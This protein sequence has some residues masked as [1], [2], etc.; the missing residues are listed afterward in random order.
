MGLMMTCCCVLNAAVMPLQP[1]LF[2]EQLPPDLPPELQNVDWNQFI[3]VLST[4][5]VILYLVVL[6]IPS[7][8]LMILGFGVRKGARG[9]MTAAKVLIWLF[10]ALGGLGLV[11]SLINLAVTSQIITLVLPALVFGGWLWLSLTAIAKLK[12]ASQSSPDMKRADPW[13]A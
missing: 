13:G 5:L 2:M 10:A 3:V 8:V 9:Q 12:I 4:V 6:L 11:L 7:I 1:Q